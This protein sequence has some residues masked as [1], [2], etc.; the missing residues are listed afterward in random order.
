MD[1]TE[2]GRIE[3][4]A[5]AATKGPWEAKEPAFAPGIGRARVFGPGYA[6]KHDGKEC[7]KLADA[8][9]IA[10]AREAV[11]ALVAAV[12]ER[13]ASL[14]TY[15]EQLTH[16]I[17][18]TVKYQAELTALRSRLERVEK[19]ARALYVQSGDV[20]NNQYGFNLS[21]MIKARADMSAALKDGGI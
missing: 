10:A 21:F 15:D 18:Q 17:A 12:R 4:L 16:Y 1:S 2:L 13:D 3:K 14:R 8:E 7:I 11:P 5:E 6:P 20:V 19:A 9:F